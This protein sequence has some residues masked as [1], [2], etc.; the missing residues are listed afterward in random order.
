MRASGRDRVVEELRDRIAHLE[1]GGSARRRPGLPLGVEAIDGHLPD[2]GLARGALH[3]VVGGGPDLRHGAAA[4]LFAAV[5]LGRQPGPVLWVLRARDLFAP[6]LAAAGLHPDRLIYAE[7]SDA[8]SVLPLAEEGLRHKGL[9]GVVAETARLTLTT[10]RR[11]QLAA[12]GSGVTALVIRRWIGTGEQ[13][14]GGT[15]AVTR[16]RLTALASAPLGWVS[17]IGAPR[18][19]LELLRCR[20]AEPATWTVEACDATGRLRLAPD[21]ADGSAPAD[22][23]RAAAG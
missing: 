15:V 21:L 3:E 5:V 23:R 11:L 10:S 18:W 9:A 6:A 2:G 22:A 1:R 12:E 17:G 4:A 14:L 7:T 16:W 8:A 19:R 13:H 20:G